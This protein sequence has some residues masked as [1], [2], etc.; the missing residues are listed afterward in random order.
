MAYS[1][2]L[3]MEVTYPSELSFDFHWTRRRYI[4]KDVTLHTPRCENLKSYTR[5]NL[6][7]YSGALVYDNLIY[8]NL[9]TH[10]FENFLVIS[11]VFPKYEL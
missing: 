7:K 5:K 11:F 10:G 9:S 6:Y 2:T 8:T 4:P 3:K 1:S